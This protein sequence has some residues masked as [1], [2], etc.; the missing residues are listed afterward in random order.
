MC[1]D[2]LHH[3]L[4]RPWLEP[5]VLL[6]TSVNRFQTSFS[7]AWESFLY[8]DQLNGT[9]G[10][11]PFLVGNVRKGS[12][13]NCRGISQERIK[14]EP[15]DFYHFFCLSFNFS[16]QKKNQILSNKD[17][18]QHHFH[19]LQQHQHDPFKRCQQVPIPDSTKIMTSWTPKPAP[20]PPVAK[21][22]SSFES[23]PWKPFST[24]NALQQGRPLLSGKMGSMKAPK[25]NYKI[26][27]PREFKPVSHQPQV[28]QHQYQPAKP[29]PPTPMANRSSRH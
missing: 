13:P 25:S 3:Q 28:T 26:Q 8:F 15:L 12:L 18:Q 4:G 22:T 17:R 5:L 23:Q 2:C 7:T 11:N 19:Q 16:K 24:P 6:H 27:M 10:P 14:S 21:P 20:T 29:T 9:T 1:V